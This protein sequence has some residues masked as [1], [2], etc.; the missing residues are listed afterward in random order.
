MG[1]GRDR[2]NLGCLE[3]K[4]ILGAWGIRICGV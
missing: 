1:A 3:K 4:G 2:E